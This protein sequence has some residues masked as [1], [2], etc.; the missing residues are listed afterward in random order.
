[1]ISKTLRKTLAV[2]LATVMA[3]GAMAGCGSK[4][5]QGAD[6]TQAPDPTTAPVEDADPTPTPEPDAYTIR[7]DENGNTYDLGGMEIVIR[8]WWSNPENAR[9]R[10]SAYD[11]AHWDYIEWAEDTYNF[12]IVEQA[13]G[14]WGSNPDDFVAYATTGGDEN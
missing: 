14:G 2:S 7:T 10:N 6:P 8:D 4:E 5:E 11:E 1:M 9:Q 13:I 3:V 12:T